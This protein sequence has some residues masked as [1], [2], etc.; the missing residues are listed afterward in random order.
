VTSTGTVILSQSVN[1]LSVTHTPST[2]FYCVELAASV[3]H[4]STVAVVSPDYQIDTT[5][6]SNFAHVE[7]SGP[8]GTNGVAVRTFEVTQGASTLSVAPTD[9][10]FVLAIP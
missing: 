10:G 5:V 9:Q 7:Y 1:V 2:G 8:C 4:S 3:P 6:G